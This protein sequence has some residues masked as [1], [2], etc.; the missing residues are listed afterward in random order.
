MTLNITYAY[1]AN[2]LNHETFCNTM[3]RAINDII[4]DLETF[5]NLENVQLKEGQNKYCALIQGYTKTG[6]CI[7]RWAEQIIIFND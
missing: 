3:Q 7:S 1:R 5:H 6:E 2:L 4:Y